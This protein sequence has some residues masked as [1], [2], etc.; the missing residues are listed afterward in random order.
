MKFLA[1]SALIAASQ[2]AGH[3]IWQDLTVAGVDKSS[4]C[5][6]M[7]LNNN[8]VTDVSSSAMACNVGTSPVAVKCAVNAGDEV[9]IEMHQQIGDRNCATEG[10]GGAHWG[11]V[12]AYMAA[13]PDSSTAVG[14][15]LSW[16]KVYQDAWA[17][18]PAGGDASG[19]YWGSRDENYCCGKLS[20]KI[21]T[22]IP[23]GDYLLRPE[24]IALHAA[25]QPNGAQL[26]MSCFQLTVSGG[27]G[28]VPA[29]VKFPGA[30]SSTDPGILFQ[31]YSP[32]S[33]YVV[34]GP[35]VISGGYT[36][37]PDVFSFGS[38]ALCGA[39]YT[40]VGGGSGPAP[41]TAATTTAKM[42]TAPTTAPGKT[43]TAPSTT[44][45]KPPTT[46]SQPT[47]TPS[48]TATAPASGQTLYG[49]CGGS[50]WTG[51]TTCSAG[52]CKVLNAYFSQCTN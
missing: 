25:G 9:T 41:T 33:T 38:T 51:P 52:T 14:T 6:R 48:K 27:A 42:T 26:Y 28:S 15:S 47:T 13:T 1:V 17:K 2:V 44:P 4:T 32:I 50:G 18:N 29:G 31:L 12:L 34:P 43:T 5:V 7:P 21:P 23:S 10:I 37:V 30:Y 19:D 45:A 20:F 24:V 36:K 3:S 22:D 40:A 11:P 35:S 16:F 46:V 39:T 8:P 49:Q